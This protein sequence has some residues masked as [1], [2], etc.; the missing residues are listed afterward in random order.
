MKPNEALIMFPNGRHQAMRDLEDHAVKALGDRCI[1][2][3]SELPIPPDSWS[4]FPNRIKRFL[5]DEQLESR[6]DFLERVP[7]QMRADVEAEIRE[8]CEIHGYNWRIDALRVI[9]TSRLYARDIENEFAKRGL[10]Y[11]PDTVESEA[12][13]EGFEECAM[14]L[15]A[16]L[17]PYL[18]LAKSAPNIFDLSVSPAQF[19][20]KAKFRERLNISD[21]ICLYLWEGED[22]RPIGL[23]ARSWCLLKDPRFYTYMPLEGIA[24]EIWS[25][26]AYGIKVWP[27]DGPLMQTE[28]NCLKV[29][30]FNAIRRDVLYG[31]YYLIADGISYEDFRQRLLAA[32]ISQ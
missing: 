15:K 7:P 3:D 25:E 14:T 22:G 12:F 4:E 21:D 11:D 26:E 24:L 2:M 27:P 28:N 9:Y 13:G 30:I 32:K 19:L 31:A 16:M 5:D 23:Y 10:Y 8:T 18:G 17:V 1:I 20:V 29:P 6:A